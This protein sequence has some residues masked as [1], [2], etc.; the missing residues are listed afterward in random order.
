M[1]CVRYGLVPLHPPLRGVGYSIRIFP[2]HYSL[3]GMYEP[4][5]KVPY[6][7][8]N[9]HANAFYPYPPTLP[10]RWRRANAQTT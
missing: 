2:I 1:R 3:L 9:S 8:W 6:S 7:E 10:F 5:S 4:Y